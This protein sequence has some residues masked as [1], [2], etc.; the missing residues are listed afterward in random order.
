[1]N[2]RQFLQLLS[3][4]GFVPLVDKLPEAGLESAITT[5]ISELPHQFVMSEELMIDNMVDFFDIISKQLAEACIERFENDF[6]W[7]DKC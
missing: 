6:I 2:R 1:M 4:L 3:A 7:A 5:A